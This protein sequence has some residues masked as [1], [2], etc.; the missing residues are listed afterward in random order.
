MIPA[1]VPGSIDDLSDFHSVQD[2]RD[3]A[4]VAILYELAGL[5]DNR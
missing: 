2:V 4:T 1:P 3:I 5:A